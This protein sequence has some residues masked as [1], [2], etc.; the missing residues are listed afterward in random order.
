M[1]VLIIG[2]GG[3]EHALAWKMRQSPQVT[4]IYV[5]PGNGGIAREAEVIPLE[6]HEAILSFV[7]EEQI[8]LTLVGT[9]NY[10]VEGLVDRLEAAGHCAFGP[11][12][13]AAALEGSKAFAKAF[14][15][16]H[17]IPTANFQT[18]QDEAKAVEY[19]QTHVPP[20][21][22]K[23]SGLA[24]GKG[25]VLCGDLA[26][27]QKTIRQML[28]GETF[29]GA[30]KTLIIEEFMSGE[31]ASYFVLTDG[32]DFVSLPSCQDYKRIGELDTGSNTGGMG[33]YSPAPAVTP[34]IE[35]KIIEQIVQPTLKGMADEG[36]RYQGVLYV[37]LMIDDDEVKVVEY[38]CRL[39]D[40]ECQ[41]LMLRLKS[42]LFE[43]F[44]SVIEGNLA[45][46]APEWSEEAAVC[47]TLASQGYPGAY[48]KG[49]IISGIGTSELDLQA[50]EAHVWQIFHAGTSL[51]GT[52]YRTQGGRVL[53]VA[54]RGEN[55]EQALTQAYDIVKQIHWEGMTY[56]RDIGMRGL[57]RLRDNRPEKSVGIVLG[58]QSDL[59]LV[60]KALPI[61]ER[62]N[63]GYRLYI[64]SAHHSPERTRQ[65]IEE[66]ET[67]GV[68]VFIAVAGMAA[69]LPGA[70]AS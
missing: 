29:G 70:V 10:L 19:L 28:S 11:C 60:Q 35:K 56:R 34:A 65:F 64:S 43:L 51:D 55:L 38:N 57:V 12:A 69:H 63:V 62:F 8:D 52:V 68:E 61:L 25:T 44:M 46:H 15:Q 6:T 16:R 5:A 66:S 39:G 54:A 22:I 13:A 37:G 59:A 2:S 26:K 58:N 4:K 67:M 23:A 3:R 45:Q 7:Q 9:E 27:A 32:T 20:Y 42:D 53:G 24:G 21:V 17:H 49:K 1:Q 36:R 33:A 47:I 14:M 41:P 40:P 50:E 30:G 48:E 31:E 18:F